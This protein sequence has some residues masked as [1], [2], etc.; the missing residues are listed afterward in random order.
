MKKKTHSYSYGIRSLRTLPGSNQEQRVTVPVQ[1]FISGRIVLEYIGRYTTTGRTNYYLAAMKPT[2]ET[3]HEDLDMKNDDDEGHQTPHRNSNDLNL[4]QGAALLTADCLGTGILALPASMVVLGRIF[5]LAFLI[6]QLP[7]NLYAGTILS[8]TAD[9]VERKQL[10]VVDLDHNNVADG[11][12]YPSRDRATQDET[13]EGERIGNQPANKQPSVSIMTGTKTAPHYESIVAMDDERF[14]DELPPSST[15]CRHDASSTSDFIGMTH[16]LFQHPAAT[17]VVMILYYCNIFLVL[18]DYM[19]VMSHAVAALLGDQ[20]CVPTAGIVASTLMFLVSQL[21]TMATLGRT[22]SIV[23][24]M[25]LFLVVIQC[26]LA[27]AQRDDDMSSIPSSSIE[28]GLFPKFSALASIGFAVG[29]QKL[30][31]NIRHEMYVRQEAPKALAI[32]LSCYVT[33]YVAIC[34]LAGPS[35][36]LGFL[37]ML[38]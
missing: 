9:L 27:L 21:R 29:S 32:S 26:L 13:D 34:L 3:D 23:S 28:K 36:Y 5:G 33:L 30:F 19:L 17:H 7:I 20:I 4:Y 8:H 38:S 16:A 10:P 12:Q 1:L 2:T 14:E 15:Q 11:S 6:L 18:G 22:V 25:A 24:L 37:N 31:L 35:K